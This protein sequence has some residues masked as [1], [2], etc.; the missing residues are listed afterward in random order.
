LL[1]ELRV[2]L[3]EVIWDLFVCVTPFV[4]QA[5]FDLFYGQTS[6]HCQFFPLIFCGIRIFQVGFIPLIENVTTLGGTDTSFSIL[7]NFDWILVSSDGQCIETT[8]SFVGHPM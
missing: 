1:A 6:I 7:F 5:S 8:Y 2:I 4:A 3:N